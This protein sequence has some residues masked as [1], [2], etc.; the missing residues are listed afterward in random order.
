MEYVLWV[1]AY[2]S[3]FVT[4]FWLQV[5]EVQVKTKLEKKIAAEFPTVSILIPAYNEGETIK[6][7]IQSLHQLNYPQNKLQII[8]IDDGST[9][10]T[11]QQANKFKNILVLRQTNKGK[12]AA[13]NYGLQHAKGE[14]VSCLDADS[15]MC[16]DS[17]KQL[18]PHFVDKRMG[19]VICAIRA[20]NTERILEKLQRLEYIFAAFMRKLMSMVNTL[21]ITPG[22]LSTYR[23]SVLKQL[24]GFDEN[25]NNLTE[26]FEI[27]LHL[28][29][30]GYKIKIET[31]S[32]GY[33]NVP[34]TLHAHY[35]QRVRWYRGF[36]YN[37]FKY[38]YM[39]FNNKYG[40]MGMFQLPLAILS[41]LML[42]TTISIIGYQVL[43]RS[44]GLI[45]DILNLKTNFFMLF[46]IPNIKLTLLNVDIRIW[47]PVTIIFILITYLFIRAHRDARER[48]KFMEIY[49][50]YFVYY[51]YLQMIYWITAIFKESI[52]AKRKW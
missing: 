42:F 33:T 20:K 9:D 7:T 31:K 22:V 30:E 48:W 8:V 1:F 21:Y 5:P 35:N 12:G 44:V 28:H 46:K 49:P 3:L 14:F 37:T 27:A 26:D 41:V 10:N 17:L 45:V 43:Y 24:E 40:M 51:P 16:P 47:F 15:Y 36:I 39:I 2:I 52:N 34:Q 19:A 38:K 29:S 18:I 11:Y 13:L 25:R 4:L 50:L 6:A 23:T 32:I